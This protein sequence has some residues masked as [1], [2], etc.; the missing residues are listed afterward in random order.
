MNKILKTTICFAILVL[1]AAQIQ[2]QT[3]FHPPIT[4]YSPKDYGKLRTPENWDI[5]QD[6]RGVIYSAVGNGILEFDG[7]NWS[8]IDVKFGTYTVSLD[9]DD[10]GVIYVGSVGDFGYLKPNKVGKLV[11]K[12]LLEKIPEA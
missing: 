1:A 11:F 9:V 3:V 7:S 8:F 5:C 12:S 2:A 4:N 6:N 10:N